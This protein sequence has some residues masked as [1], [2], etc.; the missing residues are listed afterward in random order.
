M[1]VVARSLVWAGS[2]T[3]LFAADAGAW[4]QVGQRDRR[5]NVAPVPGDNGQSPDGIA[6]HSSP[7]APVVGA[8]GEDEDLAG[9][10]AHHG[11]HADGGELRRRAG[12]AS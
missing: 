11:G 12:V 3:V 10:G 9:V 7:R 6:G 5:G 4:S 8:I 1:A 2:A